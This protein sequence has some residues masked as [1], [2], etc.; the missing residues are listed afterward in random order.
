MIENAVLEACLLESYN[1]WSPVRTLRAGKPSSTSIFLS[2]IGVKLNAALGNRLLLSS[3]LQRAFSQAHQLNYIRHQ[4]V[5][6]V[7]FST[8]YL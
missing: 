8:V 7:I 5:T 2:G 6:T 1:V 4:P 3:T